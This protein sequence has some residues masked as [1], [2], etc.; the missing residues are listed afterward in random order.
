MYFPANLSD[1]YVSTLPKQLLHVSST[2]GV[3][4]SVFSVP[5]QSCTHC[6]SSCLPNK[7][8]C[9]HFATAYL[10]DEATECV[11]QLSSVADQCEEN[12]TLSAMSYYKGFKLVSV[13]HTIIYLR[14]FL[15]SR[16]QLQISG[17]TSDNMR[18]CIAQ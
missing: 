12:P 7:Y 13:S 10:Y 4:F 9:N 1:V 2:S 3:K 16:A 11:R 5:S 8:P 18:C 15:E 17:V 14:N 6:M